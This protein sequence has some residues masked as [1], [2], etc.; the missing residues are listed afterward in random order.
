[1]VCHCQRCMTHLPLDIQRATSHR[2]LSRR[3]IPPTL[4]VIKPLAIDTRQLT[5]PRKQKANTDTR[6]R[7]AIVRQKHR[8]LFSHNSC[9]AS[10]HQK[11]TM[12]FNVIVKRLKCFPRYWYLLP[13]VTLTVNTQEA[14]V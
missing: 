1:M 13:R 9:S 12:L 5:E 14:Q 11:R 3:H 4:M 10:T 2:Q 6:K 7:L 8:I